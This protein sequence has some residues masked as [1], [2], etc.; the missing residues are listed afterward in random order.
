[1][2]GAFAERSYRLFYNAFSVLSFLPVLGV[3]AVFPG[4]EI[5]RLSGI[6]QIVALALQVFS[7]VAILLTLWKT[8]LGEFLGTKQL[9]DTNPQGSNGLITDGPYR[10]VRHPLYTL[11]LIFIWAT[12]IL[13][14]SV[15]ALNL[16]LSLYIYLGSTFE[17]RRLIEQ[18]GT[19]YQE[20]AARI[21]RIFPRIKR[22]SS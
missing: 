16:S 5:Y 7:V 14:T 17:E 6:L 11:G 4:R 13:T 1:M 15:L 20:Y 22:G 8:G 19:D 3:V 9:M 12:P 10:L 18:F 21:P 2:F